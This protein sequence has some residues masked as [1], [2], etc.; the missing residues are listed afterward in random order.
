MFGDK[1][2]DFLDNKETA[3]IEMEQMGGKF[4]EMENAILNLNKG[5]LTGN[6]CFGSCIQS[7]KDGKINP[8]GWMD[9]I[10]FDKTL[11]ESYN[12][13]QNPQTGDVIRYSTEAGAGGIIP[14][15]GAVFLLKNDKGTQVFTKNGYDQNYSKYEIMYQA[16]M[17][18]NP[19]NQY[20]APRGRTVT[21]TRNQT[22]VNEQGKLETKPV[23]E[24]VQ[25]TPFYR[26][27][28]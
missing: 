9:G 25:Q 21:E 13:V 16:D 27:K 24:T 17:L 5:D 26:P 14:L 19:E 15:H 11:G 12:N 3:A 7:T 28:N 1:Y 6:N 4:V 22:G 23:Q 8:N 2:E 18:S 20:G 10:T